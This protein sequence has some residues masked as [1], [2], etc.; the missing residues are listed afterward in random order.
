M[1]K[2]G[3]A[4]RKMPLTY[5]VMW[6]GSLALAGMPFFAGYYSKDLIIETAFAAG[7]DVGLFAFYLGIVA[8]SF[9]AFYSWRL[10]FMT[11]HGECRASDEI[12][13]HIQESP[14]IMTVPLVLLAIGALFA[15]IAGVELFTGEHLDKFWGTSI[16]ML[17]EHSVIK[18]AHHVPLWVKL[19]PLV[20][21]LGGIALA[22]QFYI[23]S[24]ET[25]K[26]L[27]EINPELHKF[28]LNKWYFDE[29]FDLLFVN[30]SK[31]IGRTLWLIGDGRIIDGFGPDGVAAT[32]VRLARRAGQLQSGYVYHYAFAMLIGVAAMV[33]WFF[34]AGG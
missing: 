33:T 32:V 19:L 7:T 3:G 10:L 16:V 23:R 8:A 5:V 14:P 15:G 17:G 13:S 11:F 29:L 1:R 26:R 9:T 27:A 25:P 2:M 18:A 34:S 20:V 6:I 30:P 31:W 21:T 12:K 24:P 22:W 4:W 28:L